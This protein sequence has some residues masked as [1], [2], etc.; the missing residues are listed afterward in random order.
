[1]NERVS[2]KFYLFHKEDIEK[3]EFQI[4]ESI[5]FRAMQLVCHRLTKFNYMHLCHVFGVV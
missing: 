4:F 5:Q 3:K 1:M 2:M